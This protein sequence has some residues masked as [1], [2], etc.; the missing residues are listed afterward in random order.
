MLLRFQSS[1]DPKA[2]RNYRGYDHGLDARVVSILT[3][4]SS[5]GRAHRVMI[6]ANLGAAQG[7]VGGVGS[8]GSS[9]TPRERRS[10][11]A[12]DPSNTLDP[13]LDTGL[14][15]QAGRVCN[16]SPQSP[17]KG[18]NRVAAKRAYRK[19]GGQEYIKREPGLTAPALCLADRS[20]STGYLTAL[21]PQVMWQRAG[22][23][24]AR[25]PAGFLSSADRRHSCTYRWR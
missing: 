4:R 9:S 13:A 22:Q 6:R 14:H 12:T 18:R 17:A 8:S 5:E 10:A 16:R 25:R 23:A 1:P 21:L 11:T 24:E 3:Q 7:G 20:V 2:G 15:E 19:L